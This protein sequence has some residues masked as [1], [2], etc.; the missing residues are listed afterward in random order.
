MC[1]YYHFTIY[2]Y[3]YV[4]LCVIFQAIPDSVL[5]S[6]KKAQLTSLVDEFETECAA[7]KN[8]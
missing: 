3:S 4:F 1:Q 6:D 8:L 2:T 7:F 5:D